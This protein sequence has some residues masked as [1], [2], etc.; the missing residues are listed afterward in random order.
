MVLE[1]IFPSTRQ[2]AKEY[3]STLGIRTKTK[4]MI[5]NTAVQVEK[6]DQNS[7]QRKL[8][9]QFPDRSISPSQ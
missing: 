9:E 8:R 3:N 7:A 6:H 4:L 5:A 1:C 2:M